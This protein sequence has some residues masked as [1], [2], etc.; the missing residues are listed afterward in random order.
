MRAVTGAAVRF[1]LQLDIDESRAAHRLKDFAQRRD[2]LALPG[3]ERAQ[4]GKR[5]A[6][7]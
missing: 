3:V 1:S 4:G 7:D 6:R 2:A 5:F